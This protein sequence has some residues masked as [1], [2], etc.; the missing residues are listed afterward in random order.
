MKP[1]ELNHI[2]EFGDGCALYEAKFNRAMTVGE[3]ME[4]ALA[5]KRERGYIHISGVCVFE[6]KYGK[7]VFDDIAPVLK[8]RT[9]AKMCWY[10]GY[11]SADYM[12]TL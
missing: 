2:R 1:F 11:S 7:V 6:F 4:Y 9:I 12:V 3:L 5:R 8:E 10:G